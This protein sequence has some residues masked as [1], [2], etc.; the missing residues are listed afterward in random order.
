MQLDNYILDILWEINFF[1]SMCGAYALLC[2]TIACPLLCIGDCLLSL[3]MSTAPLVQGCCISCVNS[4]EHGIL[5][6]V[7]GCMHDEFYRSSWVYLEQ[8]GSSWFDTSTDI[9]DYAR[10]EV[11]EK[12]VAWTIAE[13][14][15]GRMI[16]VLS[17]L[18]YV[19][20]NEC[21]GDLVGTTPWKDP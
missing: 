21:M 10:Q 13:T 2:P 9:C 11:R 3:Y 14:W 7:Q 15:F 1:T 8:N 20:H 18:N 6:Q 12:W 16:L 5:H 4:S 17:D 19:L